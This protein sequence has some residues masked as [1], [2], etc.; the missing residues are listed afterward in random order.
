MKNGSFRAS[1]RAAAA[2]LALAWRGE[3]NLRFQCAAGYATLLLGVWAGLPA[4]ELALLFLA[5][6]G[7]LAAEMVNTAVERVV[8]LASSSSYHPLARTAKDIAAGAVLVTAV[9]ALAVGAL[10]FLPRL[11]LLPALL[12]ARLASPA[13]A[14]ALLPLA[15]L[16]W[17]WLS[18]PPPAPNRRGRRPRA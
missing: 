8:D 13:N 15:A 14:L 9:A 3:R 6:A 11:H 12:A 4:P 1:L 18:A 7:V 17:G 16:L 5:A 10:L 2:G